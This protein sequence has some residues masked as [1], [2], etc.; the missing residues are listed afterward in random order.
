MDLFSFGHTKAS[1]YCSLK[2]SENA[3]TKT[4][5]ANPKIYNV[6]RSFE[7]KRGIKIR[8]WPYTNIPINIKFPENG[9]MEK[10]QPF[11]SIYCCM[12]SKINMAY[13]TQNSK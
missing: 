1:Q 5:I 2:L 11:F 4:S 7:R 3:Y 10:S 8:V 6:T 9:I 13:I 12:K